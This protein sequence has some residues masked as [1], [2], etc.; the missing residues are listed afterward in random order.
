MESR[1][2]EY[3]FTSWDGADAT[4]RSIAEW[5]SV[6][7]VSTGTEGVK[8]SPVINYSPYKDYIMELLVMLKRERICTVDHM[9]LLIKKSNYLKVH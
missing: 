3:D 2:K 4:A 1:S 8:S 9:Y 5:G 6:P 7:K